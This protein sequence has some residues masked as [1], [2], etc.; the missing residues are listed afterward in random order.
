MNASIQAIIDHMF[1]DTADNAETRAL[2]EELLNNCLEHYDDLIGRGMTETEA[3]DAVVDSLKGMKEVIDEYPK[4]PGVEAARQEPQPKQDDVPEI[5]A[6]ASGREVPPAEKPSEYIYAASEIRRLRTDLKSSDLKIGRSGDGRIHVRCED[7]EQLICEQ[8]GNT[9]SIRIADKARQS[10]EEASKTISGE[11]FTVKG[12]LNF[13]GKAIG[14]VASSMTVSWDVYV[15]LPETVL[16]EMD[17]NAKSGDID[18]KAGMPARLNAHSM[19]GDIHV[20]S[21]GGDPAGKVTIGTMSG[22]I[23]LE[24]NAASILL[25][26]M[27]GEVEARG[28]YRNV[29]MKSTSGD[30]ELEGEAEQVRMSSVSGDVTVGLRNATARSIQ[31]VSTSGDVEIEPAAGTESIHAM[32]STVSGSASCRRPDGGSGAGLQ[33][34]AKSVSGDVTIR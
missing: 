22:D 1:R 10:I 30:V 11:E 9:L 29:E 8:D 7:M 23:E 13:I 32:M 4:K 19:S 3:I 24:G 12:L 15:D 2:H 21:I 5:R 14:T 20:E 31:A 34:T 18:V 28:I 33:I 26:S 17:L 6:E 27:S 25:S 16:D